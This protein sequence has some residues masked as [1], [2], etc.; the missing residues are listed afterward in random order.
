M[1]LPRDEVGKELVEAPSGRK[2]SEKWTEAL[3]HGGRPTVPQSHSLPLEEI[4][5][6]FPGRT[7]MEILLTSHLKG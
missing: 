4:T 2:G 5:R 6:D 7:D 3:P 1:E